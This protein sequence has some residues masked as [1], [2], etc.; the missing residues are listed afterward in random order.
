MR[1]NDEDEW[2]K[3][4]HILFVCVFVVLVIFF[5]SM[6]ELKIVSS[7]IKG[8]RWDMKRASLLKLMELKHL[9]VIFVQETL[10]EK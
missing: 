1:M 7:N 9:D 6:S 8:A 3:P 2:R 10:S 4:L 5:F